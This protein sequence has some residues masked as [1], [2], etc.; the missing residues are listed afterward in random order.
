MKFIAILFSQLFLC[1]IIAQNVRV[2]S[3][4]DFPACKYELYTD[5]DTV[6]F[7]LSN[8]SQEGNLPLV[9]FVQ[10]SGMNSL[11][12]KKPNGETRAEYGHST[13]LRVARK[14]GRLLI[15]EKPGVNFMQ[16]GDSKSFDR[17]FSLESWSKTITEAIKYLTEHEKIDKNKILIAGHSEGG[18]VASRVANL[19]KDRISNVAVLAGEGP[20]QLYSLYK[21]AEKGIF[22]NTEE[23][24]MQ[25]PEQRIKYL[26]GQWKEILADPD[27]TDRKFWGFTYLRWSSMLKTSVI[28]ELSNYNGKILIVQGTSDEA[29]Y[30]ESAVISYTTLLSKGKNAE[31]RLIENADHSFNISDKP[32]VNG[33]RTVIESII[34]WFYE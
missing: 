33:W 11:Y 12:T 24:D 31:L 14:K 26:T 9:V 7:Y 3:L 2:D 19:M 21:F 5:N 22:F 13:W 27:N 34:Q 8:T 6:T 1:Q 15:V 30:P 29:V 25:T 18:V 10:G 23:A 17:K 32:D 28:D 16:M 20:P 4:T